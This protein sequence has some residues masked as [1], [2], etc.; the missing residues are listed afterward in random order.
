MTNDSGG[1]RFGPLIEQAKTGSV[2]LNVEPQTFLALEKALQQR[3]TEIQTIQR[4]VGQVHNHET[5]GVGEQSAVLTS[6]RTMVQRLRDKGSS[7]ANNAYDTLQDHWQTADEL[8]TLFRT[9]C[10]RLQQT[11]SEF[12]ARL[13]AAQS[14]TG[15]GK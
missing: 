5:W 14:N 9:I 8:Q 15:A 12:A 1:R 3:K 2:S 6:A 13:R 4:L 11:D 10:D 7:G